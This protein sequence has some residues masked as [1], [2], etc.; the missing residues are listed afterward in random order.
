MNPE[1]LDSFALALMSTLSIEAASDP[2]ANQ[3]TQRKANPSQ[4]TE[5]RG[6]KK[7]TQPSNLDNDK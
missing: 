4:H 1:Q 6:T 7:L 3:K 2:H 5:L